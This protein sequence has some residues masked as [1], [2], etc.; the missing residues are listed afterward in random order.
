MLERE[1]QLA[2]LTSYAEDARAGDGR[3]VLISGEAGIGKSRLVEELEAG[4]ADATWWWSGCDSLS[5]PRALGPLADIAAQAGGQL[6]Q[7][8]DDGASRDVRF[9]ALLSMIRAAH[10]LRVVV[11]EDLHWADEAT[12]DMLRFVG[13]R[14]RNA[15]VLVIVTYRDD[16]L[17]PDEPLRV[18]LGDLATHRSTRRVALGPL[19][20]RAI[21]V[22]AEGSGVDSGPLYRLTGGSPFFVTEVLAAGGEGVPRSARDVVLARTAVLTPDQRGILDHAALIG[23]YIDSDLLARASS[24]S[25]PNLDALVGNGILVSEGNGLRFRHEIARQAVETEIPP[26]RAVELHRAILSALLAVGSTD[27][28]RLAFHADAGGDSAR[29]LE[30]APKAARTAAAMASHRE[31]AAQLERAVRHAEAADVEVRAAST[32]SWRTNLPWS[33]V[34]TTPPPSV[35]RPS[36]CGAR[37]A[38]GCAKAPRRRTGLD[39]VALVPRPGMA[40]RQPSSPGAARAARYHRGVGRRRRL[41]F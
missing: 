39:D 41:G 6:Q 7:A 36:A 24:A 13:R 35:K 27:D 12:L 25:V 40:R 21:G 18:T 23:A 30:H 10:D 3:M 11:I 26:H 34:G 9:D 15:R 5:T 22:L 4:L 1:S 38:T 33:S 2:A 29:V 37:P 32:M 17:D 28:A 16:A 14:I 31:A 8:W 20:E 19:S